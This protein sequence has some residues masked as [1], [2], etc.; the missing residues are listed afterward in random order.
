MSETASRAFKLPI[1]DQVDVT[2]KVDSPAEAGPGTPVLVL[3]H[4]ASNDLDFSLLAYLAARLAETGAATV[5]RFNFPYAE[6]GAASPDAPEDLE[7][8]MAAVYEYAT[9]KLAHPG[10][11]VVVAGKSLGARTAA[12]LVSR[13]PEEGGIS[14]SG[15]VFLG[16]P[17]HSPSRREHLY[18]EPLR[19]IA[20]PSLFFVG[21]RDPF[22]DPEL[23]RPVV[24]N[25]LYPGRVYVVEGGD[26][27]LQLPATADRRPEDS[28]PA[29][30][31]QVQAF[32]QSVAGYR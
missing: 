26:H 8:T 32:L 19:H 22:C 5:V 29:V 21:T 25:L 2:V 10:T 13:G 17:L 28:Y 24:A 12:E 16:Y 11:P 23:L 1:P 27:S 30:V 4:G 18:L 3:A 15:L 20:V 9:K 14:A 7:R 6:R 31:E